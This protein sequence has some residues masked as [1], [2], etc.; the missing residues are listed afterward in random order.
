MFLCGCASAILA[1]IYSQ[2]YKKI[3][4]HNDLYHEIL[5]LMPQNPS[6]DKEREISTTNERSKTLL[7][8]WWIIQQ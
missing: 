2:L 4:Q 5:K 8:I 7:P 1:E 3:S 6:R